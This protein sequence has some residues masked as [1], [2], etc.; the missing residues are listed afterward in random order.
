MSHLV[1]CFQDAQQ[2]P[3][4][5][6]EEAEHQCSASHRLEVAAHGQLRILFNCMHRS[7]SRPDEHGTTVDSLLEVGIGGPVVRLQEKASRS[8]KTTGG[9][10][11][12]MHKSGGRV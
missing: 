4:L 9:Y 6:V 2:F 1:A 7:L 3:H 10:Q 8:C 12:Y 5:T 11:A